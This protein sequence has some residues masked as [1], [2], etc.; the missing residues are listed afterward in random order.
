MQTFWKKT[1]RELY[2]RTTLT[3]AQAWEM[4]DEELEDTMWETARPWEEP[5][6]SLN[7]NESK[8]EEQEIDDDD[9]QAQFWRRRPDGFAVNEKELIM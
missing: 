1:G 9:R 5:W 3:V 8:V 6:E 4:T 2:R 7:T